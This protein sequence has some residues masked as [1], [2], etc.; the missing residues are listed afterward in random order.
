MGDEAAP[1]TPKKRRRLRTRTLLLALLGILVLGEVVA[2]LVPA[3]LLVDDPQVALGPV[4][5]IKDPAVGFRLEPGWKDASGLIRVNAAGFRDADELP[6]AKPPGERRI[7]LL[8]DSQA[9][10]RSI[11]WP[12]VVSEQ[13]ERRL[14]A[15]GRPARVVNASVWAYSLLHERLLL[16]Q[17]GSRVAPDAIVLM[18]SLSTEAL[19]G[20]IFVPGNQANDEQ[21][22]YA[23]E[24]GKL[25]LRRRSR[26]AFRQALRLSALWCR[27]E[28]SPLYARLRRL[29]R[30]EKRRADVNGPIGAEKLFE[31]RSTFLATVRRGA[32]EEPPL[33]DGWAT[34][35]DEL[36]RVREAAE[37]LQAPVLVVLVPDELQV[38]PAVLKATLETPDPPLRAEDHDIDQPERAWLAACE[39]ARLQVLDLLPVF[40]AQPDPARLYLPNDLH[41]SPEGHRVAAEAI[42]A[43]LPAR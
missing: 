42:A 30:S 1:P 34:V 12:E 3:P 27:F 43:A 29:G 33:E 39:R 2:R 11:P 31:L 18:A 20:M 13:L 25:T 19:E 16:E 17:V 21:R 37:R 22:I 23:L 38:V 15:A 24:Q 41:I 28:R 32:W 8:G 10:G 40:R 14:E 36:V 7:L 6:D 35:A 5:V 26:G 4:Q 9:F